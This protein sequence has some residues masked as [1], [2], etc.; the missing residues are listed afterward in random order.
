MQWSPTTLS[1]LRSLNNIRTYHL[2]GKNRVHGRITSYY[3]KLHSLLLF[4]SKYPSFLTF[5]VFRKPVFDTP[6]T[7]KLLSIISHTQRKPINSDISQPYQNHLEKA[8]NMAFLSSICCPS[9]DHF[10]TLPKEKQ[11]RDKELKS[12]V[13]LLR[14]PAEQLAEEGVHIRG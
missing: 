9:F 4:V 7:I 11:G 6:G 3:R 13:S 2:S 5:K 10:S 14:S 8:S 12:M 1:L